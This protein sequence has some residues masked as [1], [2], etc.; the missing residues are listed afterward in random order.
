MNGISII[1]KTH[2]P[3]AQVL[4]DRSKRAYGVE[5]KRHG[6]LRRAYA[7]KEVIV[8]AGAINSPQLL[9]LSGIGPKA[10][11]DSF[12]VSDIL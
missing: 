9:M 8:S 2:E 10:H 11:L 12:R 3:W 6:S 4:I 1:V 7:S 5:Y